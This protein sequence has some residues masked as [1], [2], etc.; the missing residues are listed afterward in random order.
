MFHPNCPAEQDMETYIFMDSEH[1]T[2]VSWPSDR[3]HKQKQKVYAKIIKHFIFFF[4][5]F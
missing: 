4:A 1:A 5:K 3:K 2:G